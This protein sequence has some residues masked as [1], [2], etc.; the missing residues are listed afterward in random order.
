MSLNKFLAI[1]FL[2]EILS[3]NQIVHA[4][5]PKYPHTSCYS[6]VDVLGFTLHEL[7]KYSQI[8]I[9]C[10]QEII[11][12]VAAQFL[13]SVNIMSYMKCIKDLTLSESR[14]CHLQFWMA[15]G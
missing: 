1:F 15:H 2:F 5:C 14:D 6:H 12:Q 11:E 4:T 9:T 13:F 8:T 3:S 7:S 10:M